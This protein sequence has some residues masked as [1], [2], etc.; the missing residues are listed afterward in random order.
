MT[1]R[2]GVNRIV[3]TGLWALCIL[4]LAGLWSAFAAAEPTGDTDPGRAD[5]VTIDGL[6][7]FGPL[8]RPPVVFLHD[9]HT[10]AA[11]RQKKDCLACHPMDKDRLSPKYQRTGEVNKQQVMD[12]YHTQC[13]ACH[14]SYRQQNEASGP[15]TCGECHAEDKVVQ[16]IRQPI[17]LDRSLHY[18]HVK[19]NEEKCEICHHEYNAR[20]KTLYY[21]KGQEGACLYCHKEKTEENRI[22]DRLASHTACI[23]CHR[24]LLSQQ[25]S[26]GPVVCGGCHDPR[27]QALIKIV[28][29]PPRLKR[30]Q[31]DALL[32]KTLRPDQITAA[33]PERLMAVPFN[34]QAHE[35]YVGQCR[36]CHHAALGSCAG[37]HTIQGHADGRMVK[38]AQAMHQQDASMSCVGCHRHKQQRPECYGCHGSIPAQQVWRSETACRVCHVPLAEP[39][40]ATADDARTR[41]LAAQM[42]ATRQQ[43][44]ST[45]AVADIPETVAIEHLKDQFEAV[46]MPHRKIVLALIDIARD[47]PMAAVFH[48]QATT[49]CQGCH[50]NSPS[51]LKPPQCGA[52]HGRTSDALNLTRPGLMAAFH[53]QCLDCHRRM[54][55]E[56][57]ATRECLACHAKRAP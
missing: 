24:N 37:C 25:K 23:G 46:A 34:H 33:T 26:A 52:C 22:S 39:M 38:L 8:E 35:G 6:K 30:N 55:I 20:T 13:I 43:P 40:P 5:I 32:V 56:K 11:A 19:A 54:G 36:T 42:V 14:K 45:V 50:H 18:R 47:D 15:V 2:K 41:A 31:P 27:Q 16:S 48:P 49:V 17:G 53:Q 12:L 51:S 57:P 10:E 9:K 3:N 7:A 1:R 29:D 28:D 44:R 4:A 21:A